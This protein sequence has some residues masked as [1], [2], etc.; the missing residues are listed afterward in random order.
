MLRSI[1]LVTA[2]VFVSNAA[3]AQVGPH[4]SR[5]DDAC[6]RDANRFCKKLI[7]DQFQVLGCLQANRS[8]LS[9]GC[10]AVLQ[11]HGM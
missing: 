4:N 9:K 2:L 6:Y 8:R 3:S 1:L 10:N 7:P 11:S 5:E